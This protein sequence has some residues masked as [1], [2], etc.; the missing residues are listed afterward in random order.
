MQTVRKNTYIRQDHN[1]EVYTVVYR[2]GVK[3]GIT[4][5]SAHPGGGGVYEKI[6]FKVQHNA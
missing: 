6:K 2:G 3:G 1:F 4:Y 5:P